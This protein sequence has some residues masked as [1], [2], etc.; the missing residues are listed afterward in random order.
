MSFTVPEVWE[1]ALPSHSAMVELQANSNWVWPE[2]TPLQFKALMDAFKDQRELETQL[3]TA[4]INA[5]GLLDNQ[6]DA[7]ELLTVKGR[8]AGQFHFKDQPEKLAVLDALV[9]Y[10][11]GRSDTIDEAR[12][13]EA[14]WQKIEAAWIFSP[15]HDLIAY[16]AMRP[17]IETLRIAYSDAKT[18]WRSA[19]SKLTK[20]TG[21]LSAVLVAW[22]DAATR[23]FPENTPEGA[24]LRGTIPTYYSSAQQQAQPPATP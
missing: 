7:L 19:A 17:Q 8:A 18:N 9:D 10:G 21:E 3:Q 20:M 22:Y 1:R 6:I 24:M 2:M 12:D 23:D 16:K 13:F 15:G 11:T 4:Q 5:R 14:A